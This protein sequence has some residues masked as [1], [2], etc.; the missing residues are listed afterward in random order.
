M[1][2]GC[3]VVSRRIFTYN[4]LSNGKVELVI[5]YLDIRSAATTNGIE[6][7]TGF[8]EKDEDNTMTEEMKDYQSLIKDFYVSGYF[9]DCYPT[10]KV[11]SKKLYE[12]DNQ[13]NG[14]IRVM[15]D[16]L[17]AAGIS[18]VKKNLVLQSDK[19][20]GFLQYIDSVAEPITRDVY[21]DTVAQYYIFKWPKKTKTFAVEV[22]PYFPFTS[23]ISLID[24]WRKDK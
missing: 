4:I 21:T 22:V 15:F 16:N 13:L 19:L 1:L 18:K 10:G 24:Q 7:D 12:T 11:V 6:P 9:A 14:E 2:N 5:Q 23:S 17:E 3:L 20:C 8:V